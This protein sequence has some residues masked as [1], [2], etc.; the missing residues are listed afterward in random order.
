[1]ETVS[2]GVLDKKEHYLRSKDKAEKIIWCIKTYAMP[3]VIIQKWRFTIDY[4][5]PTAQLLFESRFPKSVQTYR[6]QLVNPRHQTPPGES[7]VKPETTQQNI[8]IV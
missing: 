4:V 5:K 7:V 1:M 3:Y 8:K 6:R 2:T